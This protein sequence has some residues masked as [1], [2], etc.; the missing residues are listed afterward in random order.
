MLSLESN[1][2]ARLTRDFLLAIGQDL[3]NLKPMLEEWV[4]H[5]RTVA[6]PE[7]FDAHARGANGGA[8]HPVW[9]PLSPVYL[10]GDRKRLSPHPKDMLQLSGDF[11]ADLTTGTD[12]TVLEYRIT[13]DNAEVVF[14][15]KRS[16]A[17]HA[18]AT[19]GGSRQAMYITPDT[20]KALNDITNHFLS[21]LI[22]RNRVNGM[23]NLGP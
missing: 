17:K 18:G 6:Q 1:F 11:R 13:S 22:V 12:Q 16:Y 15:S 4:T 8:G 5:F 14:G 10:A 21:G 20:V 7:I 2:N 23:R 9:K 3:Q 19:N